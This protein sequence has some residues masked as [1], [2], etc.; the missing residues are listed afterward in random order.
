VS[1]VTYVYTSHCNISSQYYEAMPGRP[2]PLMA[3]NIQFIVA[4]VQLSLSDDYGTL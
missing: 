4:A 3:S 2:I 1:S